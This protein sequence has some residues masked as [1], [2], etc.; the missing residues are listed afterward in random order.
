[1]NTWTIEHKVYTNKYAQVSFVFDTLISPFSA[2]IVNYLQAHGAASLS[3]L[4]IQTKLE[5]PPL[6]R[7]LNQMLK[8]GILVQKEDELS[9]VYELDYPRLIKASYVAGHLAAMME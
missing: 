4:V 3:D 5:A 2:S 8:A 7:H 9:I 1:M 6:Q